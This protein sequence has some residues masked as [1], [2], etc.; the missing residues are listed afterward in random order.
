MIIYLIVCLFVRVS[1]NR[2]GARCVVVILQICQ[3][4]RI[5][6]LFGR[7]LPW[8]A[9]YKTLKT[10]DFCGFYEIYS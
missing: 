5:S 10:A 3:K 2:F 4:A 9:V 6:G 1:E 7:F 8:V